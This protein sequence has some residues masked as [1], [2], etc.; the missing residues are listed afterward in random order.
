MA[1]DVERFTQLLMVTCETPITFDFAVTQPFKI[2][3]Q[4]LGNVVVDLADFMDSKEVVHLHKYRCLLLITPL[5]LVPW[6]F[7]RLKYPCI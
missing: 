7:G 6:H 2:Q 3:L 4:S 1:S 5:D